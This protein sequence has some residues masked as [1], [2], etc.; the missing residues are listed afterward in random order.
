MLLSQDIK[1]M[2]RLGAS[3]AGVISN[4]HASKSKQN[5]A[6]MV[7]NMSP[8]TRENNTARASSSQRKHQAKNYA[9]NTNTAMQVGQYDDPAQN[10]PQVYERTLR[11]FRSLDPKPVLNTQNIQSQPRSQYHFA[12]HQPSGS[13]S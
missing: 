4:H 6:N 9:R 2:A 8:N 1:Q 10:D 11:Q 12:G 5:Y 13:N 3:N 7:A